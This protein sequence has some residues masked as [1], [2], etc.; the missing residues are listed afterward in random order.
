[1]TKYRR[2]VLTAESLAVLEISFKEVARKM[3][4]EI[5]E[6]NGEPDH[7]HLLIEYF[8]KLSISQMVNASRKVVL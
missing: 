2:R 3:G 7:V 1:L 5:E 8:P 6:F 4:F